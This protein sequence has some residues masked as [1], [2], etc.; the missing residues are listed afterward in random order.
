MLLCNAKVCAYCAQFFNAD[1]AEQFDAIHTAVMVRKTHLL[2][3]EDLPMAAAERSF[4]CVRKTSIM[5]SSSTGSG[6]DEAL[7]VIAK[8][9][10]ENQR[11][12]DYE[13]IRIA[14]EISLGISSL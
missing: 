11:L 4:L 13:K 7:D 9:V 8:R 14:T 12:A 3:G 5:V 2:E 1:F 6:K 10:I